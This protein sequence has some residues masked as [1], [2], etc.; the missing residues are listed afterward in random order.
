MRLPCYLRAQQEP[1]RRHTPDHGLR[2]PRS[3]LKTEGVTR[4]LPALAAF[5]VALLL[6]APAAA[7]DCHPAEP[8]PEAPAG[9]A[10]SVE[11]HDC[12]CAMPVCPGGECCVERPS[13]DATAALAVPPRAPEAPAVAGLVPT[14]AAPAEPAPDPWCIAPA[15]GPPPPGPAP[16]FVLHCA[17]LD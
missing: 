12:P 13:D 17:F 8:A 7:M 11:P 4:A 1:C 5:V 6:A 15:R 3:A 16:A 14:A 9:D 10:P 2:T